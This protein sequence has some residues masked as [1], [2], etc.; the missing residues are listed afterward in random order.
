MFAKKVET[1]KN[2]NGTTSKFA[3]WYV[4]V[5]DPKVIDYSFKS[6]GETVAS[7]KFLCVLVSND[8]ARYMLG[9]VPF[10]F[11]DRHAATKALTRFAENQVYEI[12]TPAFDSKAR[13]ESNGC[14]VKHVLLL[15]RPTT[16]KA[17]PPQTR[18]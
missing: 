13:P 11:S 9:L 2:M 3:K 14:P 16:I 6:R 10:N 18:R 17:V 7:Q 5:V 15:A 1:L 8:P 4:R 12:T